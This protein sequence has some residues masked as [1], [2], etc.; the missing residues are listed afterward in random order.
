MRG[1]SHLDVGGNSLGEFSA[2]PSAMLRYL[3]RDGGDEG[4]TVKVV[5]GSVDG[6]GRVLAVSGSEFVLLRAGSD[7]A[8]LEERIAIPFPDDSQ[9]FSGA[10]V[11]RTTHLNYVD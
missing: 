5:E 2:E 1:H 3:R 10:F 4:N 9:G 8:V 7:G 6:S 11:C